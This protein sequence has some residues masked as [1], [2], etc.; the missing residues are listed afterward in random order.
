MNTALLRNE[1][2]SPKEE[3]D[4]PR[5]IVADLKGLANRVKMKDGTIIVDYR[6]VAD[7]ETRTGAEA[8]QPDDTNHHIELSMAG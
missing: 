3:N 6:Y 7:L 1:N 2:I 4:S 8:Q 5:I